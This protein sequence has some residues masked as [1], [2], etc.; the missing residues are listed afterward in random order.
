[1]SANFT[2]TQSAIKDL[3][4]FRFWC[5]KVLP[6]VYDDS[7]SYYELLTKVVNYL[8]DTIDNVETLNDNVQNIYDAY[9]LLQNYVN[10]YFDNNLPQLVSDKLDEMAEDGT[11][12]ALISGYIDPLFE[13]KTDEIDGIIEQQNTAI[14]NAITQQNNTISEAITEQNSTIN[15]AI[16]QQDSDI[17]LLQTRMNNFINNHAGLVGEE[18]IWEG[19]SP[20]NTE[21]A[22]I[23]LDNPVSDYVFIDIY[24]THR[25]KRAV[26][27]FQ[28]SDVLDANGF[29]IRDTETERAPGGTPQLYP[30]FRILQYKLVHSTNNGSVLTLAEASE[31]VWDGSFT[32]N[33]AT[34]ISP[35]TSSITKV[36]GVNMVQTDSEV[37]D[38]RV[39]VDGTIY[40][41]LETRLN[42]EF[43]AI[44]GAGL[45]AEVKSALM[46][47]FDH[48]GGLFTDASGRTYIEA[49]RSA[50]Y[51]PANLSYITAVYTQS[52]TVYDTDTLD[53]LKSDLVVTAHYSNST[54]EVVTAYTLIGTLTEGTST[55][56]VAYG[57]KTTTFT[58]TVTS[59]QSVAFE[60]G[61]LNYSTGAEEANTARA[62]SD[63]IP[64][65]G[66]FTYN[67]ANGSVDPVTISDDTINASIGGI[68]TTTGSI[69]EQTNR[70]LTQFIRC[71]TSA[72]VVSFVASNNKGYYIKAFEY[73][74]NLNITSYAVGGLN[75]DSISG[76]L[77]QSTRYVRI[78]F[79]KADNSD[80]TTEELAEIELTLNHAKVNL[81]IYVNSSLGVFGARIYDQNEQQVFVAGNGA[82]NQSDASALVTDWLNGDGSDYYYFGIPSTGKYIRFITRDVAGSN[83]SSVTGF[84][85][86]DGEL[87]AIDLE[88]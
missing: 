56:T 52:G 2:P 10:E 79:K 3:K 26:Q 30:Y 83:V 22:S 49:L 35:A 20:L 13:A 71:Q 32:V 55:I 12:T 77:N 47:I 59:I 75:S 6:T 44:S 72:D 38:A 84:V 57:G 53:S 60:V 9:I 46:A 62:R 45:T 76:T 36:V 7:L 66:T 64:I 78:L 28:T 23:T 81:D 74:K 39:G 14:S 58:V 8:N 65:N 51:P 21:N 43:T 17:S 73:D 15:S 82:I 33:P 54:T 80:F 34:S 41:N 40:P 25:G 88:G 86:V 29:Y 48:I 63:F 37:A 87:Y 50:L 19:S 11:L 18:T 67:V 5:Q 61:T 4:P 69:V 24:Y 16:T 27:R 68:D 70:V 42:T 85:E 1:M 31:S